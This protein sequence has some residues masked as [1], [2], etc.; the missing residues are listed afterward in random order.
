[1]IMHCAVPTK[2][3][4]THFRKSNL[5]IL[6]EEGAA[7]FLGYV[8]P[9]TFK[10][11]KGMTEYNACPVLEG[12]KKIVTQ[13]IRYGV[14]AEKTWDTFDSCKLIFYCV[15]FAYMAN[16]KFTIFPFVL[17]NIVQSKNRIRRMEAHQSINN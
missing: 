10:V 14:N 5:H 11:D 3:G 1:M 2:G 15:L 4:A 16:E 12:E 13:W 9:E 17:N 6:A 8:D 7:I